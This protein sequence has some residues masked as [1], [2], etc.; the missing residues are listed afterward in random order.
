MEIFE[1][2]GLPSPRECP[3]MI[4]ILVSLLGAAGSFWAMVAYDGA[5]WGF[6]FLALFAMLGWVSFIWCGVWAQ[7]TPDERTG[8]GFIGVVAGAVGFGVGLVGV[9]V[10]GAPAWSYV[11]VILSFIVF[12]GSMIQWGRS[13]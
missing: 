13:G 3:G 9:I 1:R 8:A 6:T 5:I 12:A 11:I 7:S 2:A 10:Y 4:G